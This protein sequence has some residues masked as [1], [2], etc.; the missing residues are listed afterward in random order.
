MI[1]RK[2]VIGLS[3]LCALLFC[4]FAAQ[5]AS[6]EKSTNT[7]AFTC[8]ASGGTTNKDFVDAHCDEAITPGK[9]SFEHL[10]IA[11]DT[12]TA[13]AATNDKVTNGTKDSEP[14]TLK[15]TIG[16]AKVDILCTKV[17]NDTTKSFIHNV[18]SGEKK[19]TVTGEARVEYT[20][21]EVKELAKCIV[22]EPIVAE[23]TFVGTEG[24]GAAKNEM[25]QNFVGKG[26]E[27]TFAEIQFTNKSEAEKCSLDKK[28]FPVKGS[29]IGTSGPTTKS[30]QTNK[31][32][33]AT[34]VFSP[35]N[36][37]EKLFLGPNAAEF[38]SIVTPTMS[39]GNPITLTTTT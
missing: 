38:T 12:T 11:N 4:A 18:D 16:L 5:S 31:H 14:A 30:P 39:G 8:V 34:L 17:K 2:A 32:S 27:E 3:L 15:G 25:G 19:H 29:A 28:I 13:L 21:C 22:T 23:A 37:M 7:T 9:G 1:G 20:G 24:L 35:E 26:K 6:A 33:G 36:G 10:V